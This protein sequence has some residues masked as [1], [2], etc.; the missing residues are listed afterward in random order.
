MT[1]RLRI[2]LDAMGGDHAPDM[3]VAGADLA[4]ERCSNVEFLFVGDEARI[5]ALLDRHPALKSIST[6]RHTPDFVAMDAKPSVALR[7]GR[8]SSM[9]LAIDA[10]AAGEAACVV[11]AGNTGAL[12]AIAKFV[13]KT[14]PGID[15]PAIASI[16]P[17]L[18]GESVMLDMG[19]NLECDADNL[20]QFAVMGTVF[21]RTVLGLLEPSIGL[22]NVG[23]EEQKGHESIREAAAALRDTPLARNFH[24]FVE[25]NDI[26]AG[27]VDVIVTDG[28]TGNVALKAAEG[29]AKLYSE[30]LKR[31]FA[32]SLLAKL[33]YLL[34]RGAF[35]KLRLRMD[36][37]RYNGAMF[38]GLRGICVKS[39]GGTDAI[40]FS[41][42]IAVA[43]DMA[44]H[45]FNDKIRDQLAVLQAALAASAAAKVEADGQG[46]EAAVQ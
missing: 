21:S 18:R 36:P 45:G 42:A 17:T 8:S 39:H 13:L 24:G 26:A 6:V 33:G 7:A 2:A 41:N 46:S 34:A 44:N 35:G 20:V 3:V 28:F 16:F 19:A 43:A 15:R 9:R 32:S 31:T 25:G 37:R 12:M 40:G 22:L 23:S 10:V 30:F 11:S 14:L 5:N 38:L 29:T 1:A 4:R 27:T